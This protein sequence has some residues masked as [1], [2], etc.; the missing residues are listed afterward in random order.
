MA[1]L[2][3]AVVCFIL[4]LYLVHGIQ[5]R[6]A[7]SIVA[8]QESKKKSLEVKHSKDSS[9][10]MRLKI[11]KINVDAAIEAVGI[12][13]QG[14]MDVPHNIVNVGWF[15]LGP[16]PGEKGSAVLAGHFNGK[17][18]E[19]GVFAN[20]YMLKEGDKVYIQDSS[21]TSLAFVVHKSR[22]YDPGYADDVFDQ[23]GPPHLNLI[24]CDGI[25]DESKKSYTKR[26]VV[27]ADSLTEE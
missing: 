16:R 21:G 22:T 14:A 23:N 10:P 12:T 13:S 4:L 5:Q 9:R 8:P 20:L 7:Q 25:W 3:F 15:D 27:F 19:A 26:L 11:P 2:A 6:Q 24:T 18:G 17:H 1:R